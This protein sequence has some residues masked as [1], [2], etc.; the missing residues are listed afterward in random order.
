[1]KNKTILHIV[2]NRPQ[3]IKLAPVSREFRKRGYSDIILHTGQHY[4]ANMS[5]VFFEELSI[6][7][8]AVNLNIGS[9]SHAET[10]ASALVGIE[11][12]LME[13][14]PDVVVL[15]GDTNSTL[16]GALAASKL[17]IPMVHVEAGTRTHNQNNPEEKNRII[18]D[19][20]S[21]LLF[22]PDEISLENL[23]REGL[24]KESFLTGDVMYDAFIYASATME[25]RNFKT[26][27]QSDKEYVLMT[28]HRQEN[29]SSRERMQQIL[30][31]VESV[32]EKIICPLHPRTKSMLSKYGLLQRADNIPNFRIIE[33]VGYFEMIELMNQCKLIITDSG[34]LSKESSFAGAKCLFMVDL[35]V[36]NQ[37]EEIG[38]IEHIDFD[39]SQFT[40]IVR[41]RVLAAKRIEKSQRPRFY[42]DGNAAQKMI[43]IMEQQNYI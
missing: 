16:A 29:T 14:K 31:M 11:K 42:G 17:N 4:D 9:G 6:P 1:M 39:S 25:N 33:P 21:E 37:L 40:E 23:R 22:C 8:P 13:I 3:F 15:Y 32:Q 34:G 10:T 7:K 18:V 24:G 35:E 28:W 27:Q 38:W 41:Q 43:D 12:Q 30:D 26:K 2:G 20:L 36:W 5:E 19:H